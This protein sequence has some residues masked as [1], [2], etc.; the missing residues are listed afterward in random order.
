MED[1]ASSS[2]PTC[3]RFCLKAKARET[4]RKDLEEGSGRD[5]LATNVPNTSESFIATVPKCQAG[6]IL[7]PTPTSVAAASPGFSSP[8]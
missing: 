4:A 3:S 2:V 1:S 7:S 5:F 6:D 8:N